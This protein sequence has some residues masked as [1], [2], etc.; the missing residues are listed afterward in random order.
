MAVEK[1]LAIMIF[2]ATWLIEPTLGILLGRDASFARSHHSD[3][4]TGK[5]RPIFLG[6]WLTMTPASVFTATTYTSF[7][8]R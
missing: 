1:V 5:R 3:V 4:E 2:I 6:K 8:L 7:G